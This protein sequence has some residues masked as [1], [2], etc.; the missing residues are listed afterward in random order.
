VVLGFDH[1]TGEHAGT[2]DKEEQWVKF[3]HGYVSM[4]FFLCAAIRIFSMAGIS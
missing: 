3:I 4:V 2:E 1:R